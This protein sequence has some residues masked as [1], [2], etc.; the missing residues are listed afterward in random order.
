MPYLLFIL[1]PGE[2]YYF[3]ATFQTKPI[4]FDQTWLA[5]HCNTFHGCL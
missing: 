2:Q 1:Y 5:T 3:P 4:K